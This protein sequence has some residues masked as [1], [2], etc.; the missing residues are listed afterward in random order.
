MSAK[1]LC[2]RLFRFR[3]VRLFVRSFVRSSGQILLPR[4]LMNGLNNFDKTDFGEF[5][6][7]RTKVNV[8]ADLSIR[9][10]RHP[11]QRWGVEVY[12]LVLAMCLVFLIY[13]FMSCV[14]EEMRWLIDRSIDRLIDWL[15]G[16]GVINV[17]RVV[18]RRRSYVATWSVF[19]PSGATATSTTNSARSMEPPAAT[20]PCVHVI[21]V[22]SI[23]I[24]NNNNKRAF[25]SKDARCSCNVLMPYCSTTVYL[26]MT[27]PIDF[28]YLFSYFSS[29][30]LKTP[31]D[32]MYRG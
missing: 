25:C 18:M 9:R 28:S 10:R 19:I 14:V 3:F 27:A 2:F 30:F 6:G 4:Y 21:N 24:N 8:T 23:N 17:R 29:N 26:L 16:V 15:I 32:H 11:H 31:R 7:Q 5:G 22:L 1:A 13:Y 20:S 12:F